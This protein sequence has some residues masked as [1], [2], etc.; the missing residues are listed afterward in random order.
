MTA[1]PLL[2]AESIG[3]SGCRICGS[4]RFETLANLGL[5]PV[6]NALVEPENIAAPEL[7]FPL[8]AVFC[9]ECH[10]VQIGAF[11]RP[12]EIFNSD[13]AYF[14]SFSSTWLEHAER[15]AV[16]IG[17]RLPL[18]SQDLVVEVA[19]N[20]GYLLKHFLDRDLR[21]I[22]IEPSS[23]VAEAAI[24]RGID[25]RVE[26]FGR[27][28]ARKL[29]ASA[30]RA[31]LIIANNVLAHVPDLNDFVG[32]FTELLSSEGLVSIEVPHLLS[33][34]T[35]TQFDTIYHEHYSYFSLSVL[36][37]L[38]RDHSM[39]V[40]DVERIGTHGGSLRVFVRNRPDCLRSDVVGEVLAEEEAAGL[41][42]ASRL[43]SFASQV[44]RVKYD[45]VDFLIE[46]KRN[47]KRVAAYGAAAKGTTLLN[48]CGVKD[49]LVAFVSDLSPRK[50][51]RF[52]PGCRIAIADPDRIREERPDV[53]LILAWNLR[54]EIE[55]QLAFVREWDG[56]FAVAIPRLELF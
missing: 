27:D 39:T 43:R 2:A 10:L 34:M 31:R 20:D 32:G 28:S 44:E 18:R 13:Y 42:S 29:A 33:L 16:S 22:G 15:F 12:S 37:R 5:S 49:D 48:Y 25:T 35:L 23:N 9:V 45:L 53:I 21:V 52:V 55:R 26:F 56:K 6:S 30:G 19:S 47:G 7:F 11:H 36:E 24:A 17:T 14:S 51:G 8:H 4:R 38:F 41:N 1:P 40:V 54:D 50:R 3:L 46:M